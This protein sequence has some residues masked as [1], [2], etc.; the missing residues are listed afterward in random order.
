MC[1]AIFQLWHTFLL[2]F[3]NC[4]VCVFWSQN[5]ISRIYNDQVPDKL[6]QAFVFS[7]AASYEIAVLFLFI[8]E[9]LATLG[10]Q[11]TRCKENALVAKHRIQCER[12][13]SEKENWFG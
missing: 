12:R 7:S 3:I 5:E 1:Q 11:T 8:A 9:H 13:K 2:S 4:F 6:V 10:A